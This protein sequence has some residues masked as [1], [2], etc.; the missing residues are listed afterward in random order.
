[1]GSSIVRLTL[2]MA[3][4]L[5][6]AASVADAQ[7]LQEARLSALETQMQELKDGLKAE[8]E[9]RQQKDAQSSPVGT[10]VAFAGDIAPAGWLLCDGSVVPRYQ[11]ERLW[12]VIGTR[13]GEGDGTTTFNLPDYRGRFLRGV[14]VAGD[15]IPPRDL[16]PRM[17]MNK[18]GATSGLGTVQNWA[19]ARPAAT[20]FVL[21]EVPAHDHEYTH[22]R[23]VSE[24]VKLYDGLP[25][26]LAG[27]HFPIGRSGGVAVKTGDAGKHSHTVDGGGDK[28]TRP[29]NVA[30]N[31]IIKYATEE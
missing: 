28:E 27:S 2:F 15:A 18:G 24:E 10:V 16:G 23:A 7:T 13:H 17:P 9:Q 22:A 11:Y 5:L 20:G 1:M 29:L 30:V 21:S 31:F 3:I 12:K 25:T 26:N 14:D 6:T 4:T 8:R 19:T